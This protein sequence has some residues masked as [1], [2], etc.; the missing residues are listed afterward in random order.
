MQRRFRRGRIRYSLIGL[1]VSI[2]A[3]IAGVVP[4][5][6]AALA[7]TTAGFHG[8][9]PAR[10][11][12]T[13]S[14][15]GAPAQP[16]GPAQSITLQVAGRGGV[17]AS[18]AI[19]VALNVTV[20]N[21]TA[22]GYITVWPAAEARPEASNLNFVTGQT[23]PNLVIVK[24]D[25]NGQVGLFN[26][27]GRTDLLADVSGWYDSS[28]QLVPTNPTRL[29]D[30]RSTG[31][32]PAGKEVVAPLPASVPA[33]AVAVAAN[34]TV[35]ATSSAGF[36]TVHVPG[37]P[38]PDASILNADAAG[39]TRAASGIFPV[40]PTGIA[41]WTSMRTDVIVDYLGYFTASSAPESADGLFVPVTPTRLLDTR[42]ASPL[43]SGIPLYQDGGVEVA[44]PFAA[45]GIAANL[46]SSD[47][48]GDG[49]VTAFPAR[50][51]E[52][53]TSSLNVVGRNRAAVANL[54]IGAISPHGI[55]LVEHGLTAGHAIVD[56]TGYFTGAPLASTGDD[57]P[58]NQLA[59]TS[60][61]PGCFSTSPG[62][63]PV[64]RLWT[65][66]PGV[67]QRVVGSA[68]TGPRG[69]IVAM[70]D[71]IT[72]GSAEATA[73]ALRTA[74]WGPVC[75]DGTVARTVEFGTA[76]I[77]DGIDAVDRIRSTG[78]PW[79]GWSVQW[80]VALGTND[81]SISGT[82]AGL[83]RRYI[84]DQLAAIGPTQDGVAW[85]QVRTALTGVWPEREDVWNS[86][87]AVAGVA[88]Q[89]PWSDGFQRGWVGS[90][91]IHLSGAGIR[92][93]AQMITTAVSA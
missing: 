1:I 92:A 32:N 60:P 91:L 61:M 87:L 52:P 83:A 2:I 80:V 79:T 4:Q 46:T 17:P 41:V 18:G 48:L 27:A 14:G 59:A 5:P 20:T 81:V 16:I 42:H 28:A 45:S 22:S 90:D 68:A 93:R 85:V 39:Q 19:A 65:A 33:D 54:W 23:I 56:L 40:G 24:L 11:L 36:V 64:N 51:D 66:R 50:T 57:A 73:V 3:P 72:F 21:P 43:G 15:T 55:D 78:A 77:P 13:R 47:G 74:G 35:D 10:I 49:F 44:V 38:L 62:W 69:P 29:L 31:P 63:D 34:V 8:L 53:G 9:V 58:T 37:T 88:I 67:Y 82:S 30:T 70:G 6:H 7:A 84:S 86:Q 75:I 26:S 71:S 12:D 25:A 89:V 76:A